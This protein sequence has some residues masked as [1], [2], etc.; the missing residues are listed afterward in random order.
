MRILGS[1]ISVIGTIIFVGS[2]LQL[3]SGKIDFSNSDKFTGWIG[4][5]GVSV[6]LVALG[7]KMA[8]RID[9]SQDSDAQ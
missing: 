3:V 9:S 5:T 4:A 6:L 1:I 7:V 2:M 8:N